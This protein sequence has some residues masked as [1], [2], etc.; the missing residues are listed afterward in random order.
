V[1]KSM[2]WTGR[3][4]CPHHH[5]LRPFHSASS[6][7]PRPFSSSSRQRLQLHYTGHNSAPISSS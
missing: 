4:S 1:R 5:R 6:R 2:T 7:A 3:S